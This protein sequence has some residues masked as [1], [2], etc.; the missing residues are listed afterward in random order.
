MAPVAA[1]IGAGGGALPSILIDTRGSIAFRAINAAGAVPD[2][3]AGDLIASDVADG[4]GCG[5]GN[6]G[7]NPGS[8]GP[9]YG[10]SGVLVVGGDSAGGG[11]KA[12]SAGGG[13]SITSGAVNTA[14]GV[15]AGGA[16]RTVGVDAASGVRVG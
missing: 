6:S 14:G 9:E 13:A 10:A 3:L 12:A 15:N 2:G 8:A 16:V 4:N 5:G 1:R 7:C 11:V